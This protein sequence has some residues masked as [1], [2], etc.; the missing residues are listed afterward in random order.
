MNLLR[1][2]GV[3]VL[4]I[5]WASGEAAAQGTSS[6]SLQPGRLIVSVGG[7]WTGAEALGGS[8]G[9]IRAPAVGSATPPPFV[10]FRTESELGA[11]PAAELALG[12]G[13]T[14]AWAIEVRGT[15]ARP[16]LT[17]TITGDTEA[18]GTF[19]A[20]DRVSEY[21][22]D[23]SAIYHLGR[24]RLGSRTRLYVL[25]GGGY[26][27]QLHADEVLAETGATWHVGVGARLWVRGGDG[28]RRDLGLTGDLRWAWRKN[29]I[30]LEDSVRSVPTASLRVFVRL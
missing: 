11:A 14:R 24:P 12:V 27:R 8:G 21:V 29:G 15:T 20:T 5:A 16:T 22:V 19:T 26:L 18:S 7:G 30:T 9:V 2:L 17:T 25:G 3:L 4:A 13:V 23:A 1:V 10:L 28:R 6:P